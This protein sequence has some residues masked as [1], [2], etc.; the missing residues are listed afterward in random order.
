MLER[1]TSSD[2]IIYSR[3]FIVF[4]VGSCLFLSQKRYENFSLKVRLVEKRKKEKEKEEGK[5][6]RPIEI[7]TRKITVA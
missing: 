2:L 5:K 3:L 4:F 7:E 6:D 1:I